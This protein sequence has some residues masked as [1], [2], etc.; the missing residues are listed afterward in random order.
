MSGRIALVTGGLRGLGRSM[1]L[2]L[3]AAGHSVAAVGHIADDIPSL[4]AEAGA[5]ADRLLCLAADLRSRDVC[6]EVVAQT[7]ARFGGIDI[8]INNAGLTFTYTD[9]DRFTRGPRMS[10]QLTDEIVQNT[11]D[12]NYMVA[13][14]LCRRVI[15]LL[16][17]RGWGRI[18]N[19]TTKLDTM[20]RPGSIPYGP[21]K[22]ALE[23][24]SEVWAK[25]LAGTGVT[26]NIVNP[27]A[28]ANTPGMSE[29]MREWSATGKASRLVEPDDM[30]PPLLFVVSPEAAAVNG[31]RFD[32]NTW[33]T[34]VPPAESA[35]LT[36]RRSGFEFY[37][38]SDPFAPQA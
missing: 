3:L 6:T 18:I 14:Q 5:H 19:V 26:C 36:G 34:D 32:A 28:G 10:W 27:G 22:A 1:A 9:P 15:P 31:Y 20:N 11:M 25:E 7:Q 24:A 2:G 17:E 12:T 21:S 16:I 33:R 30:I 37:P 35:R 38:L 13:D 4:Q 29:V 23:M 8:L